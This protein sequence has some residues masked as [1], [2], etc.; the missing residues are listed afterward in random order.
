MAARAGAGG[1]VLGVEVED[2]F[3][4][5]IADNV[6]IDAGQHSPGDVLRVLPQRR[7]VIQEPR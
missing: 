1:E 3:D 6:D 2:R 5:Q 4:D 7:I